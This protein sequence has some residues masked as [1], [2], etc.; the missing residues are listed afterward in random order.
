MEKNIIEK[1]AFYY[2][3]KKVF[4]KKKHKKIFFHK[5]RKFS[6]ASIS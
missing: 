5:L 1:E 6:K 4:Y 3:Y 2:N